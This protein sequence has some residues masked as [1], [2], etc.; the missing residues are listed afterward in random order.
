M[1]IILT[2]NWFMLVIFLYAVAIA[3]SITLFSPDEEKLRT[4]KEA[5]KSFKMAVRRVSNVNRMSRMGA[6]GGGGHIASHSSSRKS[7]MGR[8]SRAFR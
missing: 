6:G 1:E 7:R 3:S 4:G 5:R 8:S 2:L